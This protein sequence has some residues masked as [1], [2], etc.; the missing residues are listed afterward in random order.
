MATYFRIIGTKSTGDNKTIELDCPNTLG[1][2]STVC[3]ISVFHNGSKVSFHPY[4]Q[5][6]QNHWHKINS[7]QQNFRTAIIA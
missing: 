5:L 6:W 2:L 4:S 1:I 7:L 3:L